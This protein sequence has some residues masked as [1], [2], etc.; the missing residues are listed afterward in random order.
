MKNY[1][2]ILEAVNKG[3]QLALDDFDDEDQI[4]NI[5][6]KQVQNRDYTKEYLDL[7]RDTVDFNLPSGNLWYKCNLGATNPTETATWPHEWWGDYYAWGELEPKDDYN[8]YNYKHSEIIHAPKP[9]VPFDELFTKYCHNQK[10]GYKGYSDNL[11]QLEPEDDAVHVKLGLKYYIPTASDFRELFNNTV[12][13]LRIG[14]KGIKGLNG[15]ELAGKEDN[16]RIF[17]PFAGY[18]V[19]KGVG[20]DGT[21]SA[22]FT[23][24][25]WTSS[26]KG[27]QTDT[28]TNIVAR[29]FE[30]ESGWGKCWVNDD[31]KR[32]FGLPLRPIYRK[33]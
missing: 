26:F 28:A 3:I 33:N 19:P 17:L 27:E 14:Y 13:T 15:V 2:Q 30:F 25:L 8:I 21:S 18:R 9:N 31:K 24:Y 10:D 11:T 16:Q 1:K 5:K 32:I 7:I 20:G 22:E 23:L 6:S 4:Q 12:Q 29:Q